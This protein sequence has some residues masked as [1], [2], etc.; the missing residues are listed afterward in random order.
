MRLKNIESSVISIMT[1]ASQEVLKIY[2]Q[3]E[4]LLDSKDKRSKDLL[5][6]KLKSDNSPFCIADIASHNILQKGLEK[7]YPV[8]S[9]EGMRY[10]SKETYFLIDPL[11]GSKE[12]INTNDEFCI[13]VALI[14]K[15]EVV[16]GA[17][18]V[19]TQNII[20]SAFKGGGIRKNNKPFKLKSRKSILKKQKMHINT[21][22][23]A[24]SSRYHSNASFDKFCKDFNF[25][26]L[27][28]GSSLK[29]IKLL[30]GEGSIYP[31]F[32]GSSEWDI[33]PAKIMLQ[34]VGGDIID[35]KII[36][37]SIYE[38]LKFGKNKE[39]GGVRNPHFIAFANKNILKKIINI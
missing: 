12:F 2:N 16:L 13:N 15:K 27:V 31:R 26:K 4:M 8:V 32:Q 5:N 30:R 1:L 25:S 7:L 37:S 19:P 11:D 3:Y 29:F 21:K 36:H 38:E 20:F 17:I 10:C 39:D 6:I 33:A 23:Y 28:V 22:A 24:L 18:A 9:E 14:H 34:E 35:A